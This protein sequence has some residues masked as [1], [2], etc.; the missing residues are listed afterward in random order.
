MITRFRIFENFEKREFYEIIIP[1]LYEEYREL[2]REQDQNFFDL[3]NK[4]ITSYRAEPLSV[5]FE[6]MIRRLVHDK[7]SEFTSSSDKEEG[8]ISH[9]KTWKSSRVNQPFILMISLYENKEYIIADAYKPVKIYGK[10]PEIIEF[11]QI[12]S[13]VKKYNL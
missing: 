2:F 3:L 10:K 11:L 13:N 8:R 9:I 5:S 7:E 12:Y 6:E 1:D 4:I